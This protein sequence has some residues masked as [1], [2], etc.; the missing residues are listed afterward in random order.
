MLLAAQCHMGSKNI[1]VGF[2]FSME[3]ELWSRSLRIAGPHGAV[4]VEDQA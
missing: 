4:P 1:Q 2:Y 3:L